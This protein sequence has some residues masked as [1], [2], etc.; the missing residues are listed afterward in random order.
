MKLNCDT[1]KRIKAE[2]IINENMKA[3]SFSESFIEEQRI[4]KLSKAHQYTKQ[5][6]KLWLLFLIAACIYTAIFIYRVYFEPGPTTEPI[7]LKVYEDENI[8]IY[9]EQDYTYKSTEI[10][11]RQDWLNYVKFE[12]NLRK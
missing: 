8:S 10:Q 4:Y 5:N 7:S 3:N 6:N 12:L 11:H 2:R 9:H 1:A